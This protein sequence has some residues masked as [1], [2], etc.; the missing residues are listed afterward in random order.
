MSKRSTINLIGNTV[1]GFNC[2]NGAGIW[3]CKASDNTMLFKSILASGALSIIT[4]ATTITITGSGGTGG[5]IGW[6]TL[7]TSST[8]AGCGT[9]SCASVSY[10]TIYGVCAAAN[11]NCSSQNNVAIGVS[12]LYNSS[13]GCSGSNI[14]IGDYVLYNNIDGNNNTVIGKGAMHNTNGSY[15]VAIGTQAFFCNNN[16]LQNVIIGYVAS[17]SSTGG[18]NNVI[19]GG[20]VMTNSCCGNNNVIIGYNAFYCNVTGSS[21]VVIGGNAGYSETG[22]SKLHIGNCCLCSLIC[23]DFV[24]QTVAIGGDIES[25]ITGCGLILRSPNGCRWRVTVDNTGCLT[26]TSL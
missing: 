8:V 5:G 18:S 11:L 24:A 12:A 16:G 10:N 26:S 20:S 1:Q 13:G 4:G 3:I 23:G 9:P 2:G 21:N 17:Y 7:G 25:C 19:I 15:N 22:S 14:A 6:S